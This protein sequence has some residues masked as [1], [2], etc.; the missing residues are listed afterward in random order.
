MRVYVSDSIWL[1]ESDICSIE[2][3]VEVSGLSLEEVNDLVQ[4]GAIVPV[5][6]ETKPDSFYLQYVVAARTARRL[7]DDFELDRH[8]MALA[9]LLL[10]H[11]HELETKLQ[12]ANATRGGTAPRAVD[13]SQHETSG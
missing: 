8:G 13:S 2:H 5:D 6:T 12:V 4:S 3:L 7:R 9:L 11:I 1:N 10:R